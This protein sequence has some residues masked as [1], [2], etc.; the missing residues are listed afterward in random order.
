[1]LGAEPILFAMVKHASS[2]PGTKLALS[3][4]GRPM[5][6]TVQPKLRFWP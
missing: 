4:E 1:M 3:A 5:T 6:A 2:S